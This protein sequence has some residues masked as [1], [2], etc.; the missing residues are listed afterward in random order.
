MARTK[1]VEEWIERVVKN[2]IYCCATDIV[3]FILMASSESRGLAEDAPFTWDDVEYNRGRNQDEIND[4]ADEIE[5]LEIEQTAWADKE[6]EQKDDEAD[7]AF[8]KRWDEWEKRDIELADKI[9][10]LE[11]RQS[12]LEDEQND[13]PEIYEW[14]E[15][16]NFLADD[17]YDLG[18]VVIRGWHSYWG[19]SCT[20]QAI[21]LDYTMDQ[22]YSLWYSRCG[23]E[24]EEE[25]S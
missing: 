18:E 19:R 23:K 12:E 16:S 1:K 11:D 6:P 14:W 8:D 24:L 9:T 22:L 17:L 4:I 7:D 13:M 25:A 21:S 20:G 15:V 10:E 3:E 5:K 2:E